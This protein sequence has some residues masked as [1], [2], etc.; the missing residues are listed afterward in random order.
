VCQ[1]WRSSFCGSTTIKKLQLQ[2][3]ASADEAATLGRTV[4]QA[5]TNYFNKVTTVRL[6]L[7]DVQITPID[8]TADDED[9]EPELY[10][11]GQAH[12]AAGE[13]L[14]TQLSSSGSWLQQLQLI[15]G[16]DQTCTCLPALVKAVPQLRVLDLSCCAHQLHDLLVLA[17]HAHGLQELL[18]HCQAFTTL[19]GQRVRHGDPE[20][21]RHGGNTRYQADHLAAL[22]HLPQLRLLEVPLPPS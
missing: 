16:I 18:L 19:S 8:L 22:A 15:Q 13:A 10:P 21:G 6:K 3:P 20:W 11:E 14:L 1:A 2:Q 12:S 5:V 7:A 9:A 4:V 17:Q